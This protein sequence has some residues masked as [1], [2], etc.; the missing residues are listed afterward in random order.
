[1]PNVQPSIYNQVMMKHR[2]EKTAFRNE[3][4]KNINRLTKI[5]T[6]PMK[7]IIKIN[8]NY[9]FDHNWTLH[10]EL[11]GERK[12][13][14]LGQ[15]VKF[16]NRVLG[17]TPRDVVQAIGTAE[18]DKPMGNKKLAMFIVKTLK[19]THLINFKNLQPWEL[20]AE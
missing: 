3:N 5:K 11:N 20:C 8:S 9:G 7:A 2:I 18:I 6:K 13:F 15:D 12:S 10:I 17:M 16:C 19:E 14:Y 1:V 4:S